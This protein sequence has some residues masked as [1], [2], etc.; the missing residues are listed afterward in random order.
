AA[1]ISDNILNIEHLEKEEEGDEHEEL[2]KAKLETE[3]GKE[4]ETQPRFLQA[5]IYDSS[6]TVIEN[7]ALPRV[8]HTI[9]VRIGLTEKDWLQPVESI[10]VDKIFEENKSEVEN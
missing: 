9:S 6:G 10:K 7:Y 2:D 3:V 4:S 8:V 5:K 1:S